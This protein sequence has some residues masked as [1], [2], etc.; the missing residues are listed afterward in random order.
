MS[1]DPDQ[2][3]DQQTEAQPARGRDDGDPELEPA[4]PPEPDQ[5]GRLDQPEHRDEHH[6]AER[7]LG[8]VAQHAAEEQRAADGQQPR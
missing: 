6:A 8:Q 7:R 1:S 3:G 4:E 5:L 2:H